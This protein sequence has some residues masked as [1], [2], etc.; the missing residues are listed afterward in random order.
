MIEDLGERTEAATPRRRHE[1]REQGLVARSHDLGGAIALLIATLLMWGLAMWMLGQGRMLIL[2]G[3][4][5]AAG[6]TLDADGAGAM[7]RV[8][9][10]TALRLA[11]PVLAIAWLAAFAS[12]FIQVGWLFAPRA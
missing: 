10:V 8:I 1:A 6:M 12:Q 11:L 5:D 3:L 4:A 2:D 9:G 7:L